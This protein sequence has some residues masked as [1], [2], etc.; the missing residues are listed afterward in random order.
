MNDEHPN[1]IMPSQRPHSV[2][3]PVVQNV[4]G[5]VNREN[6]QGVVLELILNFPLLKEAFP[7][8][9]ARGISLKE[10]DPYPLQSKV[11]TPPPYLHCRMLMW[12]I[13]PFPLHSD[14]R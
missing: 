4:Q 9:L 5:V 2:T 3:S 13:S 10:G 12:Q 14:G 8:Q 6:H 11:G 1:R 7:S